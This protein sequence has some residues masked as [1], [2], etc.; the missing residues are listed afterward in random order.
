LVNGQKTDYLPNSQFEA[1]RASKLLSAACGFA[2]PVEPVI[3]VMAA[4]LTV[5]VQPTDVHVVGRK[6]IA[7]WLS[8]RPLVLAP[9]AVEKIYEQ[10][11]R[12]STCQIAARSPE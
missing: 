7:A 6:Q 12:D 11:L 8:R 4:T 10:A 1:A 2:V 3:V 9:E 5:K